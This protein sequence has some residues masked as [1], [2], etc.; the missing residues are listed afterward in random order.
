MKAK[1]I[2]PFHHFIIVVPFIVAACA[3]SAGSKPQATPTASTPAFAAKL[4]PVLQSKMQQ[5]HIPGAVVYV[6]IPDQGTWLHVMGTGNLSTRAPFDPN[7]YVRIGSI[8]K[9]ITATVILQLAAK[10][11]VGLDDPLSK[12]QPEFPNGAHISL[13]EVL[14]H[15]GGIFSY[16]EDRAFWQASDTN[17]NRVWQPKELV[18][19]AIKHPPYFPPG[20]GF[21]YSDTDYILLGMIIEQVTHQSV[22]NVFQQ[23]VFAP[24]GMHETL[25]PALTSSAFSDPHPV[26]YQYGSSSQTFIEPPLT[27]E[28][29]T[30]ANASA[31]PP[32]DVTVLNPSEGWTAGAA[33]STLHDLK[34]WAKALATGTLLTTQMQHERIGDMVSIDAQGDSYGLGIANING[35]LGH[36]GSIQGFTTWM[37]YQPKQQATVIVETNL[38]ATPDKNNPAS[39]LISPILQQLFVRKT[40][41]TLSERELR[42]M[43]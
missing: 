22:E 36:D 4:Q 41:E 43:E 7:S 16:T 5:Y 13:R 10:G 32:R 28:A 27:G 31:G 42:R 18:A 20:K 38:T 12:Y 15:M 14:N 3:S 39:I 17:P 25:M 24:L 21:H 40:R 34:I 2:H 26:G 23:Q 30:Q 1:T 6:D 9:T 8:T 35:L 37:L 33:I 19:L 29:A 11:K